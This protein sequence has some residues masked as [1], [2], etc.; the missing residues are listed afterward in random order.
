M[1]LRVL[2]SEVGLRVFFQKICPLSKWGHCWSHSP[3]LIGQLVSQASQLSKSNA[4]AMERPR[5]T[6]HW[7]RRPPAL[8]LICICI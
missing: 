1:Q 6:Q 4:R 2:S 5:L 3:P 7:D 8:H